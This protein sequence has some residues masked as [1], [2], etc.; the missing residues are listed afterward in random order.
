MP[1]RL[2]AADIPPAEI[3]ISIVLL[4]LA[5]GAVAWIAGKIYRIGILSTGKKPTM[6]ELVRWVR[7]A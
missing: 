7:T 6:A 3:A 2:A 4:L 1:M 5:L